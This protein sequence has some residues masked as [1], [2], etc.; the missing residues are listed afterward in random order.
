[1][2]D[3]LLNIPLES[4]VSARQDFL[5][6]YRL[7]D[8][9]HARALYEEY[10]PR[11][12]ANGLRE[13]IRT[14]YPT[15]HDE[16]HDLGK[17]IFAKLR[18][19]GASLE[20]CADA[21]ASGCMHGV[22]MQFFTD[23][24]SSGGSAH[25]HSSQ[26]TSAD[27]AGRIPT[28]CETQAFA[29]MYRPGDCAH[30]VGHAVMFLSHYDVPAGIDLCERFPSYALRYYCATGAYMEYRL[31]KSTAD[32]S[33]HGPFYPCDKA[34]YPAACFRYVMTN[35]VREHYARGATL[36]MLQRQCAGLSGK[37]RLGCFHGI[38]NAHVGMIAH[39]LKTLAE[40]C[41][42][43]SRQDQTVCVEGAMERLGKFTP[44][45]ASQRCA[46]LTDWRREVCQAAVSRKMYDM[47]KSFAL[48]TR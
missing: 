40:V 6:A 29:R 13:A 10:L 32:Y 48:Y 1:M 27:V 16:G 28:I 8:R 22:L 47:E 31:T 15:C 41:S 24:G 23:S 14:A 25:H 39:G 5:A 34:L 20:S 42:F 19:V 33:R 17:V 38:G 30:G 36:E 7:A 4:T 35:T 26:L 45:I 21:C 11:I 2:A 37:Y 46:S 12:G 3:S 9:R 44:A 18:D 43:G